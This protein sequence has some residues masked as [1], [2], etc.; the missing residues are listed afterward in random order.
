MRGTTV[1]GRTS[2]L[3][4]SGAKEVHFRVSSPPVKFPCLYGVDF[5]SR[6][7]LIAVHKNSE[8]IRQYIGLDSLHHLSLAGLK[9]I[10]VNPDD[11]CYACFD[12]KYP[13]LPDAEEEAQAESC[14]CCVTCK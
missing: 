6:E 3:R 11:F 8:E 14:G 9:E 12:G 13:I 10:L 7:E 2:H 5:P 4:E 1:R